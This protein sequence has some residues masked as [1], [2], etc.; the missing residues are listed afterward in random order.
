[1]DRLEAWFPSVGVGEGSLVVVSLLDT[2]A[3][4]VVV[5]ALRRLNASAVLVDPRSSARR[6]ELVVATTRS[7]VHVAHA[8][9]HGPFVDLSTQYPQR[10]LLVVP[11]SSFVPRGSR[12]SFWLRRGRK[13]PRVV[14]G[15]RTFLW[16]KVT[17]PGARVEVGDGG[18][19]AVQRP[20]VGPAGVALPTEGTTGVPK[21]A[22][23]SWDQVDRAVETFASWTGLGPGD[24]L[25]C[26]PPPSTA[27][28]F[29]ARLAALHARAPLH[30]TPWVTP[31]EFSRLL[32]SREPSTV[33]ATP[34]MLRSLLGTRF[35]RRPLGFL[36]AA[37][38]V[39]GPLIDSTRR[40][41]DAVL[42]RN[43]STAKVRVLYGLT[44]TLSAVA[45]T[46][47]GPPPPRVHRREHHHVGGPLPGWKVLVGVPT[48]EGFVE[49]APRTPGE[50]L[51]SG[52]TVA[53]GL[54]EPGP[55]LRP[56]DLVEVGG[57]AGGYLRT[58]DGG[59]V[60]PAGDLWL[61]GRLPRTV[62]TP[63]GVLV[64][65]SALERAIA[66]DHRVEE[67]AAL[68]LEGDRGVVAFVVPAPGTEASD[69]KWRKFVRA[70]L[71]E[72][73]GGVLPSRLPLRVVTTPG[74]LPRTQAGLVDY[75][76]LLLAVGVGVDR[77]G[78][79]LERAR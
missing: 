55:L 33:V 9:N 22:W 64:A 1:M 49:A 6:L 41:F 68:R 26:S 66:A 16:S 56:L 17:R 3:F 57:C 79:G 42:E 23:F 60:D 61:C 8:F 35:A 74:A 43:G 40:E 65:L 69:R 4:L 44:E 29:V 51:V 52:P 32:V 2:P 58:G 30:Q 11:V 25:A 34:S 45:G 18:P 53:L 21:L 46:A 39:R 28:G 31:G 24:S 73:T 77:H 72:V 75:S 62:Q 19:G 5:L 71:V 7:E 27:A 14:P 13:V 59:F 67:A 20:A 76:A 10:A 36:R 78:G 54:L 47:G 70:K 63:E 15:P 38:S 12:L 37:Y 48:T 50:V